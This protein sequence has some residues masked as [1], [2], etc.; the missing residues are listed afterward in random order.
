[1]DLDAVVERVQ[2]FVRPRPEKV[3][4]LGR[5][6]WFTWRRRITAT[7]RMLLLVL[8]VVGPVSAVIGLHV[9]LYVFSVYLFA[10][11]L[12]GR[13]GGLLFGPR[14]EVWRQLPERCAAGATLRVHARVENQSRL[15]VFDLGV[16]E[17]MPHMSIELEDRPT[18][19]DVLGRGESA[20]LTYTMV[21]TA[22]GAYDFK[23]PVATT[24]FP[25]GVYHH[26]RNFTAPHRMLVY[27]RFLPLAGVDQPGGLQMVSNVG[28]SEEFLGNREY[29]PGDRLRD[30]HHASWARVGFPVVREF[31][32]EYLCRIAMV[33]D[34]FVPA[35][36]RR[37]RADM[38]AGLSLAAAVADALSRQEYVIDIFAAGPDLY[39]FQAGRSLAYL[40][41]ILDVLACIE[42]CPES[43]FARIAPALMEEI[44]QIST[45]V[46]VFLD[47]NEERESFVRSLRAMGVAVKVVVVR[48]DPPRFDPTGFVTEAGPVQ[49][50]T[51]EEVEGGIGRL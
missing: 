3:S 18:Y 49:V 46:M 40:D 35:E 23:G 31:Q 9:P 33:V 42:P 10:L 1:M 27:P 6:I 28:D 4:R 32:Q 45:A 50:F 14:V 7:G 22:R 29:R 2:D 8:L 26:T 48:N 38:E 36:A 15:A 19:L 5:W 16:S 44:G 34:T 51:P 11:L 13:L 25:F 30:I 47:W 41:N 17:R 12:V 43:P 39:H 20:T 37:A 24:V 21:A